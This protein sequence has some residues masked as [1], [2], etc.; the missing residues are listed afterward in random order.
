MPHGPSSS[1]RRLLSILL[2]PLLALGLGLPGC[3]AP[4]EEGAISY[5]L[6]PQPEIASGY[7][8]K[9]GW[10]F[11]DFGVAA[12][13]PLAA[14]AGA[15]IL[16]AGGSAV[17][18]AVA[19]QMVL[20]LVEPQS[21]GIG[22]GAFL[23]HWDGAEVSAYNGREKAPAGAREDHFL[24]EEGEPLPF[25]DAVE[26]G[27]SV[28][29]PGTVAMLHD[30][31]R[32][33]G[34]L[35]W[36]DLFT[37]AI[38]LASEGFAVSPR[39]HQLLD[40]AESLGEDPIARALYYDE[41][42]DAHPVGHRLRNPALAEVLRR[43][44]QE[45]P[46]AFYRGAVAEDIVRRVRGHPERPGPMTV[47][48]V[49]SYPDQ[50]FRVD[51]ICT[52]WRLY[53]LCGFPPPSSGHLAVAQIL[54]LLE[55]Q[56]PPGP[57]LAG[58]VPTADWLHAYLE[59]SKLAF[60]DRNRY[61]ADPA[62]VDPPAGSWES[63]L[64]P[65]YLERRAE[66]VGP[67]SIEGA[68]AGDPGVAAVALL[69][70]QPR[71]PER[72]TSHVSIVD[73]EGNAVSMTTTIESGFGSRI[74]SDGG[75]G[76]A[77]GFH[78]NNELTDFSLAPRDEEGLPI[79]NRVEPGKRP[80]SSMSPTLVFRRGEAG[81]RSFVAAVGSP[82]GAAIIHYTAKAVL[83][84]LAWGLDPQEATQVPNFANFN[85]PSVLEAGRFPP[86]VLQALEA[87]GHELRES[88]LTSGIHAIL[89]TPE[90]YFAGA[91]PR[92]EGVGAGR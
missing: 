56:A 71:Q 2:A 62:F 31:H 10:S 64:D 61:V 60:A 40:A 49:A 78:L 7:Q 25:R 27:L 70:S 22:G 67:R 81:G 38:T 42:G 13:H 85:G 29:V 8:E 84:M 46:D 6:P 80:R 86:E 41:A 33:H 51:P 54:G 39:L 45:G 53:E 82:G 44:A 4:E 55:A 87:R 14:D 66:L 68:E 58:G 88:D 36:A 50:E 72:G 21:S 79:A 65:E 26:S 91:D 9:P 15:Q 35:P 30:A 19:V 11:S 3:E 59:A 37:P 90:G 69:G 76:L 32:R 63:L 89:R 23:L 20:T 75:T 48:D 5:E 18:A 57:A 83:G 47:E 52:P 77:G 73:G 24:D 74:M 17:D 12:A 16:E 43:I 28:G 34:R 1:P 92:R